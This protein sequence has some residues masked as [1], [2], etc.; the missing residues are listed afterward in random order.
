MEEPELPEDEVEDE[1]IDDIEEEDIEEEEDD[2]ISIPIIQE[3]EDVEEEQ[4]EELV[5]EVPTDEGPEQ[6]D[7]IIV[8]H[9]NNPTA[10]RLM[11]RKENKY[12]FS[13]Q[14]A[15]YI[16]QYNEKEKIING[17]DHNGKYSTKDFQ[18]TKNFSEE[19]LWK[20]YG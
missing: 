1:D 16:S 5:E 11:K 19:N 9:E 8:G 7:E 14:L 4:V 10:S 3:E 17:L 6:D 2:E 18:E 15:N 20:R 12:K 13:K